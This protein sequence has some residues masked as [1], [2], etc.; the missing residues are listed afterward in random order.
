MLQNYKKI[1]LDGAPKPDF[2]ARRSHGKV[3]P[4]WTLPQGEI[5]PSVANLAMATA[6]THVYHQISKHL[7]HGMVLQAAVAES[8]A[9]VTDS[10]SMPGGFTKIKKQHLANQRSW[11]SSERVD[12]REEP[13]SLGRELK[14]VQVGLIPADGSKPRLIPIRFHALPEKRDRR[15]R[16]AGRD[17][18]PDFH[19]F[20]GKCQFDGRYRIL[21]LENQA[22]NE[23]EGDYRLYW[24]ENHELPE[25]E[26]IKSLVGIKKVN[27]VRRF[28]YGD[29][30]VVRF[31][32]HPKTFAYDVYDAPIAMFHCEHLET[33][34]KEMWETQFL[35]T[36]LEDDR[37]FEAS[38]EKIEADKEI[39][40]GR[41]SVWRNSH[42][43]AISQS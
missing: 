22:I 16:E 37:F 15:I 30:F 12:E 11:S 31:S 21:T 14:S 23:L 40:L 6:T 3:Y 19:D 25:N 17:C 1:C 5:L 29:V 10:V 33:M 9:G 39:I 2:R 43:I 4:L 42:F 35:E 7:Q 26:N 8:S 32:E 18:V 41:M 27:T 28:W 13:I 36:Q 20:W 34:F 38:Q 24:N